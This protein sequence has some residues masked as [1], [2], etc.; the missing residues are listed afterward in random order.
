MKYALIDNG[1]VTNT[2]VLLP[3]NAND[4]PN[5]IDIGE[6]P[7]QIG[8]TYTNGK[9]Y[10][11]GKEVRTTLEEKD[12]EIDRMS[13]AG[14]EALQALTV[15]PPVSAGVFTFPEWEQDKVYK[16]HDLFTYHGIVGFVRQTHTSLAIYPPFSVGT[17]A[18]YGAR[19]APDMEGIYPYVYNMKVETG[20][21][22]KSEK[23]GKI[24]E[25]V[26]NADPLSYDPADASSIFSLSLQSSGA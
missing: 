1:V 23:D 2:V 18:L 5:A 22:V 11:D 7:V 21:K 3:Y 8:D 20:M 10:R 4:F 17:E 16:Q 9:F 13:A 24:Y 26:Q 15:D 14:A 25:A 12:I 19:P 6:R